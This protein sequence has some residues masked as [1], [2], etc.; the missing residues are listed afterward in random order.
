MA[1]TGHSNREFALELIIKDSNIHSKE[2]IMFVVIGPHTRNVTAG[3]SMKERSRFS[4]DGNKYSVSRPRSDSRGFTAMTKHSGSQPMGPETEWRSFRCVANVL[5]KAAHRKK[6]SVI[7]F[8]DIAR[9]RL[10]LPPSS[11]R[12]VTIALIIETASTSE[13]SVNFYQTTWCIIPEDS[14]FHTRRRENPKSHTKKSSQYQ[15][16]IDI[17]HVCSACNLLYDAEGKLRGKTAHVNAVKIPSWLPFHSNPQIK[18]QS[19]SYM[20]RCSAHL[21]ICN[22]R[23]WITLQP[24]PLNTILTSVLVL[25]TT[26]IFSICSNSLVRYRMGYVMGN[27][28]P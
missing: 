14:N 12:W 1:P 2:W 23:G 4:N 15:D 20:K 18:L 8:W 25:S 5:L 26:N 16:C 24:I 10:V 7:V 11:G 9:C 27:V 19:A 6:C 17:C 3:H 21:Y 13:T 28:P 22:V